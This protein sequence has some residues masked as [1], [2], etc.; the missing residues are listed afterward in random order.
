[1]KNLKLLKLGTLAALIGMGLVSNQS[2]A[3]E[4]K[5]SESNFI[6]GIHE[7][8]K[9]EYNKGFISNYHVNAKIADVKKMVIDGE[10]YE[11]LPNLDENIAQ[12][13]RNFCKV[14]V[15]FDK[16]GNSVNLSGNYEIKEITNF[17]NETQKK[18][19][20]EF[21]TL[22]EIFHCELANIE[23]PITV[24]GQSKEFNQKINYYLKDIQSETDKDQKISY[25]GVLSETFG[26]VGA[27]GLLL[28]RYGKDNDDLNFVIKSVHAQR[29]VGYFNNESDTHFT[30]TAIENTLNEDVAKRLIQA[31]DSQ[32]YR[33]EVLKIS[34]QSVQQLI[35]QRKDLAKTMFSKDKLESSIK[36][37]IAHEIINK[38]G[39]L[40]LPLG[41]MQKFRIESKEKGFIRKLS[42]Q[43]IQDE[44]ISNFT[45]IKV[46]FDNDPDKAVKISDKLLNYSKD[47]Y[48]YKKNDIFDNQQLKEYLNITKQLQ[49]IIYQQNENKINSF[50]SQPKKADIVNRMQVIKTKFLESNKNKNNFLRND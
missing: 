15:T 47:L 13:A 35:A 2:Q 33:E 36:F 34:N 45:N 37:H 49:E 21:I 4:T 42:N 31:Q 16:N 14:T 11:F 12:I 44:D 46:N 20:R 30:H 27:I 22:H 40:N 5:F 43:F 29:Y 26:D 8:I 50:D 7:I 17:T 19:M 9:E 1:M 10:E 28:K 6:Q 25:F 48:S 23:N 32:Q 18:I 3:F 38:S 41:T 24:E 39:D